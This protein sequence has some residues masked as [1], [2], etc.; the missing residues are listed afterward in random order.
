MHSLRL[1][2]FPKRLDAVFPSVTGELDA[3]EGR[4]EHLS[5][6][7]AVSV[8][9]CLCLFDSLAGWLGGRE[10]REGKGR[11]TYFTHTMPELMARTARFAVNWSLV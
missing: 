9:A 2:P 6:V 3:A 10:G 8:L 4:A 5:V 7:V 11:R 1:C